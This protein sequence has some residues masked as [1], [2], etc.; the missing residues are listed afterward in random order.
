MKVIKTD[1]HYMAEP[2]FRIL[3]STITRMPAILR[4]LLIT[5]SSMKFFSLSAEMR[6]MLSTTKCS[7]SNRET[8]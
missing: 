2:D 4:S 7:G 8:C 3:R 1:K 6:I 5:M